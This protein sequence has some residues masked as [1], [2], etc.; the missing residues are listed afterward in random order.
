[1]SEMEDE[2]EQ[3]RKR[4][5]GDSGN[6]NRTTP[7]MPLLNH[8]METDNEAK[9]RARGQHKG[10]E[11]KETPTKQSASKKRKEKSL[12]DPPFLPTLLRNQNHT[13]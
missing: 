13:A 1:M 12:A 2:G 8:T 10:D 7:A 5:E 4:K 9:S 3:K 6:N 11:K